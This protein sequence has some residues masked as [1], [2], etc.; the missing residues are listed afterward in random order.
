MDHYSHGRRSFISS[1]QSR[2]RVTLLALLLSAGPLVAGVV[3][4]ET[5]EAFDAAMG[6]FTLMGREDWSS[7]GN[8]AATVVNSPLAPGV[9]NGPFPNGTTVASGI[10][11]QSNSLGP[12][13]ATPAPGTNLYYAPAGFR[14]VSGNIQPSNQLSTNWDNDS[15]DIVFS[16]VNGKSPK[17]VSFSPMF[18]RIGANTTATLTIK[19]YNQA[20]GLLGTVTVP[21][22]ADCLE[23]AYIG[24]LMTGAD[25]LGRVNIWATATDVVGADNIEVFSGQ[26]VQPSLRALHVSGPNFTVQIDGEAGQRYRMLASANVAS[27]WQSVQTNTLATASQQLTLPATGAAR[28]YRAELWP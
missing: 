5:A 11:V 26:V 15:F 16:A 24:I 21:D 9:A 4:H 10:R 7:A 27:G 25:T 17:A 2:M 18:Y 14:G 22:V 19:V 28:F 1:G 23:D 6:T 8:A 12:N 13:G 20:D 3:F